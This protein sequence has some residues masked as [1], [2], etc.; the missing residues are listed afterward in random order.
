MVLYSPLHRCLPA[1]FFMVFLC[2]PYLFF[3][4]SLRNCWSLPCDHGLDL[5]QLFIGIPACATNDNKSH[6]KNDDNSSN[7][8]N[9]NN[10]SSCCSA[11]LCSRRACSW[12]A[13]FSGRGG[14]DACCIWV[15]VHAV[16]SSV[17]WSSMDPPPPIYRRYITFTYV[18]AINVAIR[19]CDQYMCEIVNVVYRFLNSVVGAST[20]YTVPDMMLLFRSTHIAVCF[21]S[22]FLIVFFLVFSRVS[23][24]NSPS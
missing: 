6:K 1:R 15:P 9:N 14:G 16:S 23:Y 11:S 24:W 18:V 20:L 13:F 8:S 10:K 5:W 2:F 7:N 19:C 3:L 22:R 12:W 17:W 4:V 21:V